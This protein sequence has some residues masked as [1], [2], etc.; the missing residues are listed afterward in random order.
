LLDGGD[1]NDV[2]DGGLGADVL[3]GGAGNDSFRYTLPNPADLATLG[4]D[5]ITGFEVGK[6]TIDLYDLFAN[7]NASGE[8]PVGEGYLEL[9]VVAG[10]TFV[11]FD[12][13]GGGD[14]FVLLATLLGVT[15]A[16]L[17]DVIVPSDSPAL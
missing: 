6:D 4:G 8:D 11:R 10:N 13:D 3:I 9:Q 15:N 2:I 5:I 17:A 14:N 1:G 12:S 7:F 16:T